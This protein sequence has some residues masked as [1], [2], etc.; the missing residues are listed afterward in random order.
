MLDPFPVERGRIGAAPRATR[1]VPG[2][3]RGRV[4]PRGIG[5][6]HESAGLARAAG[7]SG[8]GNSQLSR[9][10]PGGDGAD[11]FA[12]GGNGDVGPGERVRVEPARQVV[13]RRSLVP[14]AAIVA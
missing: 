11:L 8:R 4:V 13:A 3:V 1:I 2:R 9:R 7:S 12:A 14:A 5:S 10:T 6:R